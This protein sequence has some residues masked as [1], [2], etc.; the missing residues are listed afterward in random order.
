MIGNF[1]DAKVLVTGATGFIGRHLCRELLAHGASVHGFSRKAQRADAITWWQ[2]DVSDYAAMRK[3]LTQIRPNYVFHLASEVTGSRD[4]SAVL[5]TLQSNLISAV[6]VLDLAT[7]LG[8]ERLVLA[9]SLEEPTHE[10]TPSSPYAAAKAAA[11]MYAQLYAKL[12]RAPVVMARLFMVYGPAQADIAKLIPYVITQLLSGQ[13]PRLSSGTRPVD[14][15][16]VDDVVQGLLRCVTAPNLHGCMIDIGSG[17]LITIR[18]VVERIAQIVAPDTYLGFGALPDRPFE[19]VH[20]AD[21]AATKNM[22]SW[23]PAITLDQGLQAT[24]SH[25]QQAKCL[26]PNA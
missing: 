11:S 23:E 13:T 9:G 26:T 7:D 20:C 21:L 1:Q 10:D 14:W 6:N 17:Q 5:P 16:Y 19:Q 24:I 22:L 25:Y 4:R 12:Y 8:A 2:V 18:A 3:A 15:I